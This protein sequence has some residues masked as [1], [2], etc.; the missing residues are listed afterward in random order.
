M[1]KGI[2]TKNGMTKIEGRKIEG[3]DCV[4]LENTPKKVTATQVKITQNPDCIIIADEGKEFSGVRVSDLFRSDSGA[5]KCCTA[6][7]PFSEI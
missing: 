7:N 1:T 3:E 2:Y 6:P 5:N 4:F